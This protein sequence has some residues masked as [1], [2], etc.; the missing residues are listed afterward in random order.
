MSKENE[1][2]VPGTQTFYYKSEKEYL[3]VVAYL[4]K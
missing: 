4:K 1:L 3:T 2:A